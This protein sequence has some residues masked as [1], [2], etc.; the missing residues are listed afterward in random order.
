LAGNSLDTAVIF[1]S[2]Q[3]FNVIRGPIQGL[4]MSL[5]ALGD[6]HV[7]I[8]RLSKLLAAQD[9]PQESRRNSPQKNAIEVTGD[10]VSEN[11]D[12][13]IEESPHCNPPRNVRD[14][15]PACSTLGP[16]TQEDR[17]EGRAVMPFQLRNVDLSIQSGSF[18]CI[19][20]KVGSGK[21]ALL[22][23]MIGEMRQTRGHVSFGGSTS[24]VTQTP[25]IQSATFQDN[26]LFG[27]EL[28]TSR[29]ESVIHACALQSDLDIMDNGLQT[30]IGGESI[31]CSFA[32]LNSIRCRKRGQFEWR[33][34]EPD[35]T[36]P[37]RLL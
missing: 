14:D 15:S 1:A 24:L 4:P 12:L 37:C 17:S 8:V 22:Q 30:D 3:L 5:T 2:L 32:S 18:V 20:G 6:A 19:L 26:I 21:S 25:W 13:P 9:Q 11:L 36:G 23:A 27:K 35:S 31:L 16:V 34:K 28:D 33:S 10:F 29:L 7:A